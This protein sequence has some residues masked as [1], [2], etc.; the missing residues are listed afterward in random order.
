[1]TIGNNRTSGGPGQFDDEVSERTLLQDDTFSKKCC[2]GVDIIC[3]EE[4]RKVL[5]LL[6][7]CNFH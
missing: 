4:T 7:D 2:I 5:E 6:E 3:M 1:M